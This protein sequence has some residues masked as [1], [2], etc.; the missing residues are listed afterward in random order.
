MS[1]QKP[2][3]KGSIYD[4]RTPTID[5]KTKVRLGLVVAAVS[6]I[7]AVCFFMA[8]LNWQVKELRND[9]KSLGRDMQTSWTQNEQLLFAERLHASNP[10]ITVPEVRLIVDTMNR[11]NDKIP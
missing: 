6:P 11:S 9:I 2:E 10:T 1:H 5:A 8:G 3:D 7:V 4:P